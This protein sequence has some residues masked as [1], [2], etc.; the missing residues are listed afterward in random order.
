MKGWRTI[1]FNVLTAI[2][3]IFGGA[4]ILKYVDAQ[5]ALLIV[6]GANIGLRFI[7][8][9]AVGAGTSADV[10]KPLAVVLL[11]VSL[12]ACSALPTFSTV[13]PTFCSLATSSE[14]RAAALALID[15]MPEGPNKKNAILALQIAEVSADGACTALKV[16]EAQHSAS[17]A[18]K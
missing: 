15:K 1:A 16:I 4:E 6:A 14:S 5:T 9:S 13:A 11:A 12:T 17:V 8:T 18:A 2:A 3:S 7:T 10:A